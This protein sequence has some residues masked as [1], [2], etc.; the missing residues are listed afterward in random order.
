MIS[1]LLTHLKFAFGQY[2]TNDIGDGRCVE[3]LLEVGRRSDS[4]FRYVCEDIGDLKDFI[5]V[6]LTGG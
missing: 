2:L 5:D 6:L 1:F 3:G 4:T